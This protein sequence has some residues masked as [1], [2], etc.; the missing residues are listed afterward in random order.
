[1]DD[2]SDEQSPQRFFCRL[3][4]SWPDTF[5]YILDSLNLSILILLPDVQ[6]TRTGHNSTARS[7][8]AKKSYAKASTSNMNMCSGSLHRDT[9][10]VPSA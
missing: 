4:L 2:Q 1:M 6:R 3:M 9:V 7:L 8:K 5:L 10:S